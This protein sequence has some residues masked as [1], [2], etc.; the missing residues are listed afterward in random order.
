MDPEPTVATVY[1]EALATRVAAL[2]LETARLEAIARL[3]E[4]VP[5]AWD[6]CLATAAVGSLARLGAM[7]PEATV[8]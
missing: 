2:S 1:G 5:M 7:A 8:M 3:A 4:V 6:S